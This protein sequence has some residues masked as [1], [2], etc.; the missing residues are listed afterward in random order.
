MATV[1][2][3]EQTVDSSIPTEDQPIRNLRTIGERLQPL[4]GPTDD[5]ARA[6]GSVVSFPAGL[7]TPD[8]AEI[9]EVSIGSRVT[10]R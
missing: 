7:T 8:G 3:Q 2:G 10:H 6:M 4:L 5:L 9:I 1:A